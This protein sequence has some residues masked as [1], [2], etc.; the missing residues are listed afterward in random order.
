MGPLSNTYMINYIEAIS[1]ISIVYNKGLLY[2]YHPNTI[3]NFLQR[4]I[5]DNK[6][7]NGA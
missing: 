3:N 6:I 1:L 5:I 7:D 4:G 2:Q